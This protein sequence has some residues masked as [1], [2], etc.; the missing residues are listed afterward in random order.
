MSIRLMG[1]VNQKLCSMVSALVITVKST[2]EVSA[3]VSGAAPLSGPQAKERQRGASISGSSPPA[4]AGQ[5]SAC[6]AKTKISLWPLCR[7]IPLT[8]GS[9]GVVHVQIGLGGRAHHSLGE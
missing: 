5:P 3:S 2:C 7:S 4:Y 6:T 9:I 8:R 1:C